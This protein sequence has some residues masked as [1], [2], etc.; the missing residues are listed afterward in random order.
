MKRIL[1]YLSIICSFIFIGT[2]ISCGTNPDKAQS[3]FY[4]YPKVNVYYDATRANYIYSLD[5]GKTWDSMVDKLNK[6]PTTLGKEVI[7]DSPL[8]EVWKANEMHR[9]LYGGTLL[10]IISAD[11]GILV[12]KTLPKKVTGINKTKTDTI[13][14]NEDTPKKRKGFFRKIFGKKKRKDS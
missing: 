14:I 2:D 1:S 10:N 8:S 12:K 13:N 4:Y 9:R 3:S 11:T 7:I 6:V 5:S